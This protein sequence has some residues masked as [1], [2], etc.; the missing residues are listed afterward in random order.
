VNAVYKRELDRWPDVLV[1]SVKGKRSIA[2]LLADGGKLRTN[3]TLF[4]ARLMDQLEDM[5]GG[6][7]FVSVVVFC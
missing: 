5:D 3:P 7:S 1:V 6:K 4:K 2:S